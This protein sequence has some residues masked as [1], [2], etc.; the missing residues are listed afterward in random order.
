MTATVVSL[1]TYWTMYLVK[2]MDQVHQTLTLFFHSWPHKSQK[3][4]SLCRLVNR[5]QLTN[6]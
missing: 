3:R 5:S 4:S 2:I 1:L 6:C